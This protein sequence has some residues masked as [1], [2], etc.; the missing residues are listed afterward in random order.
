MIKIIKE[1][2]LE[3]TK[4]NLLQAIVA[5]QYDMNT[6]FLKVTLMDCGNRITIPLADTIE[7]VINAERKDGQSKGFY[8]EV[9]SDGTVTVPL[10]SWMLELDGTVVCDVSVI[11]KEEGDHKKLTTTS[12]NLLVE[13]AAFGGGDITSDPQY[14]VLVSLLEKAESAG[15]IAQGALDKSKE[16]NSK[17]DACVAATENAN[18]A[19][20]DANAVRAEVEAGG[21]IKSLQEEN[22]GKK[23]S[24]WVGTQE[25]YDAIPE[26]ERIPNCL[27]IPTNDQ[28]PFAT[29]I[30]EANYP[31]CFYRMVGDE[32][33][34]FNPPME[35]GAEYRTMER[36]NGEPV[37]VYHDDVS[38]TTGVIDVPISVKELVSF[39]GYGF[40]KNENLCN[41]IIPFYL[42][43][44]N[45]VGFMVEGQQPSISLSDSYVNEDGD[46]V[47]KFT[48]KYT[49]QKAGE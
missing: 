9:N 2:S 19:A 34:W 48:I 35:S 33:E 41:D 3:V 17:Y 46:Y 18:Q 32:K 26:T 24:V 44:S 21:F 42:S 37:Y 7:V 49:K 10:D 45:Y 5:K 12:F 13:K 25:E 43:D 14:D 4:P 38:A 6:R 23:F 1:I 16:A 20:A 40:Y 31:G 15:T 29:A 30:E 27:Y 28:N 8:G 22:K 11:D 39:S 47:I 36:R